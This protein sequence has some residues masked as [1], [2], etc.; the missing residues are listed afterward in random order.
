[1]PLPGVSEIE[2]ASIDAWPGVDTARDGQWVMRAA[3]GYTNRANSVQSLDAADD[4]DVGMRLE[5]VERWYRDRGL[6]VIFR[7]T[8]LAG[9]ALLGELEKRWTAYGHSHVMAM[10]LE[11]E[12][13]TADANATLVAVD[14]PEWLEAQRQMQSYDDATVPKLK[15]IVER[16]DAPATGII[17]NADD[18]KSSAAAYMVVVDGIVFPGNVVTDSRHRG[19]GYARRMMQSGF[20]WATRNGARQAAVQVAADNPPAISLYSG[21]GYVYQYDYHYRRLAP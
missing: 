19:K 8:P 14:S 1:V 18:G 6:P 2:R 21:L 10:S 7:V 12:A 13:F 3:N 5:H 17:V 9:P 11:A 20:A 4:D 15:A 16:F